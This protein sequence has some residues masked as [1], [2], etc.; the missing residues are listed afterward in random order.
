MSLY[1]SDRLYDGYIQPTGYI[2]PLAGI[3][4]TYRW[5]PNYAANS[6]PTTPVTTPVTPTVTTPTVP[7][8]NT[9]PTPPTYTN[10]TP[11]ISNADLWRGVDTNFTNWYKDY[12]NK[13][14][15]PQ[16]ALNFYRINGAMPANE[17]QG[18]LSQI[19]NGILDNF[20]SNPLQFAGGLFGL[21]QGF[22]Q[23]NYAKKNLALQKDAYNFQKQMALNN[24]RRNQEQWDMLKRQRASSSL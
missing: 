20:I 21:Y 22:Q 11:Y 13:F 6:A 17:Q 23:Y 8:A 2:D 24:E 16:D 10:N 18:L 14:S 3:D 12:G 9:M 7:Q 4:R 19:G 1:T 5:K 15:N